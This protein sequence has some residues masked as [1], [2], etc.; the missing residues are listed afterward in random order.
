MG[1]DIGTKPV[2]EDLDE[3]YYKKCTGF[4]YNEFL[5]E[6]K[7]INN[8][9]E[10][11]DR[12]LEKYISMEGFKRSMFRDI[13][14]SY[15]SF[16]V[17][18]HQ[19]IEII[20][21]TFMKHLERYPDAKLIDLGCGSGVFT[22]LLYRKGI[23]RDKLIAV[24]VPSEK[25]TQKFS[26]TYWNDII[27]DENY[28]INPNDMVFI[29]WGYFSIKKHVNNGCKCI[30]ILGEDDDG[31]TLTAD[32]FKDNK[33]WNVIKYEV[34]GGANMLTSDYLTINTRC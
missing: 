33:E 21:Q 28:I 14:I 26:A 31:C 12:V 23:Q 22:W 17:P 7:N 10:K 29:G 15:V 16:A 27:E 5:D 4:S 2:H 18:T 30:L 19:V 1:N 8:D 20:Y 3:S 34:L 9:Y 25:K 32:Y 24:D 13:F 11:F 6:C